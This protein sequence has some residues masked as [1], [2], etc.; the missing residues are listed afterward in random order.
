M[1]PL[2]SIL[3]IIAQYLPTALEQLSFSD[4]TEETFLTA[5]TSEDRVV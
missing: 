4:G 3:Y 1:R 2:E 5:N